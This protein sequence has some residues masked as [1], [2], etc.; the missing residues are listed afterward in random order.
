M[1]E[2]PHIL[3]FMAETLSA[4][5]IYSQRSNYAVAHSGP[6][7]PSTIC[8]PDRKYEL[9]H[10]PQEAT[11]VNVVIKL[12]L[13]VRVHRNQ[14]QRFGWYISDAFLSYEYCRGRA[15]LSFKVVV[16]VVGVR[17]TLEFPKVDQAMVSDNPERNADVDL[18][19][20]KLILWLPWLSK[21]KP[22]I[23]SYEII[24]AVTVYSHY[25]ISTSKTHTPTVLYQWR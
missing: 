13:F 10:L 2:A 23:Y 25:S 11:E 16:V 19:I 9:R 15:F 17:L 8:S 5:G 24:L 12:E 4:G 20:C 18:I 14:E 21:M 22:D 3:V 7:P 1:N 6:R